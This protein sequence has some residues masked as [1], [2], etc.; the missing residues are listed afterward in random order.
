MLTK[1][2]PDGETVGCRRGRKSKNLEEASLGVMMRLDSSGRRPMRRQFEREQAPGRAANVR[3]KHIAGK[4]LACTWDAR[5]YT[6]TSTERLMHTTTFSAAY[7]TA[8]HDIKRLST[9][10]SAINFRSDSEI[11]KSFCN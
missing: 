5:L 4:A 6:R 1:S 9:A 7:R 2:R 8:L 11:R 10:L 3:I